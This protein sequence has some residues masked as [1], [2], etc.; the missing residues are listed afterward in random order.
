MVG[1]CNMD[2]VIIHDVCGWGKE[3]GGRFTFLYLRKCLNKL[4]ISVADK[5]FSVGLR[6]CRMWQENRE[7]GLVLFVYKGNFMWI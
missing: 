6:N 1:Y 7:A 4:S 2:D 5:Q 3:K